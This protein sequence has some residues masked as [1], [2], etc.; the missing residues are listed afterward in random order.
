MTEEFKVAEFKLIY[1]QVKNFANDIHFL[2]RLPTPL[3]ATM[4]GAIHSV[5]LKNFMVYSNTLFKPC[6]GLNVV[7]GSNGSGKSS[8]LLAIIIGVGGQLGDIGR[9]KNLTD[10]I[11]E[12]EN[13]AEITIALAW[14]SGMVSLI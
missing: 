3:F 12:N 1:M 2:D 5:K 13:S 4:L 9:Q 8:L 10:F 6:K 11:K 7:I 14:D